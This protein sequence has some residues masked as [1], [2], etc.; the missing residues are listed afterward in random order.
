[1][2]DLGFL[3]NPPPGLTV[4]VVLGVA[5]LLGVLHGITPDEHTWP[6]TFSYAIGSYSTRGGMKSGFVFSGGFTIQ[7]AI[8][9]FLGFEG[10]AAIYESYHLEGYVYAIVGAGMFLAGRYML[11]GRDM[12]I[13]ID[14]LLG[15]KSHH[16]PRAE[17]TPMREVEDVRPVSMKLAAGHGFIAGW[18]IGAYASIIMFVLAP[19]MPNAAYAALV[20]AA[21]GLGTMAMQVILGVIFANIMRLKKLTIDQMK[22]VGRSAAARTLYLG[23][24]VFASVGAAV[25]ALPWL[26]SAG[27]STGSAIPNIS[28]IGVSTVLVLSTLGVLGFGNIYLGYREIT[29]TSE[30]DAHT[31]QPG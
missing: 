3:L 31:K 20:G 10:L 14:R 11:K 29:G 18:G 2:L 1:V 7:R 16:D 24:L 15:G 4:P 30:A 12:H 5:V 21:F 13:P 9:A 8:L 26:A 22:Y 17:R 28:V 6:I 19:Q 23:G 25:V 27:L